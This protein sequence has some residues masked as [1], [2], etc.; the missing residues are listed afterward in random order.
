[1]NQIKNLAQ[2]EAV[3]RQIADRT[4]QVH[5]ILDT[6]IKTSAEASSIQSS[7]VAVLEWSY[8][9]Q[10]Q[11]VSISASDTQTIEAYAEQLKADYAE[12]TIGQLNYTSAGW[13]A[14]IQLSHAEDN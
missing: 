13:T 1:M 12:V 2:V 6:R 4:S 8:K 11:L 5:E 7:Q 9:P 14:S 3:V 10:G